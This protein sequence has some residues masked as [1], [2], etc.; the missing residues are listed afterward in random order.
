VAEIESAQSRGQISK[1]GLDEECDPNAPSQEC[2]D[3]A[4]QLAELQ[5]LMAQYKPIAEK[6]KFKIAP[7]AGQGLAAL[8]GAAVP[9]SAAAKAATGLAE[10]AAKKFGASS[11]E[12]KAAWEVVAEINDAADASL[13]SQPA[14]DESCV[15]DAMEKC[16]AFEAAMAS[17]EAAMAAAK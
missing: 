14:L 4:S 16:V 3:Y 9:E 11:V 10:A 6:I 2:I 15:A 1:K 7:L 17:L 8:A 5:V 12:A 13:A